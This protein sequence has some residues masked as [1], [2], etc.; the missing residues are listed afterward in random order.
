MAD[1]IMKDEE[2]EHNEPIKNVIATR[3][4]WIRVDD[5]PA[6]PVKVILGAP[7]LKEA[8]DTYVCEYHIEGIRTAPQRSL[9]HH[10]VWWSNERNES[11]DL[12]FPLLDVHT[13]TAST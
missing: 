3:D 9:W 4:L 8:P 6:R 2:Q 1:W 13:P 10:K 12:G 7:Y 5:G 11:E